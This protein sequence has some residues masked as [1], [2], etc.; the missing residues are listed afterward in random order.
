MKTAN[1]YLEK[2]K[3]PALET[4]HETDWDAVQARMEEACLALERVSAR[5]NDLSGI[6]GKMKKAFRS[7]CKNAGTGKIFTSLIPDDLGGSVLC[8]GLNVIFTALQQTEVHREAVYKALE[9]L[10][11]ILNNHVEYAEL[12]NEDA[13]VHRRTAKLYTEVLITLDH[14]LRWFMTN[15]FGEL[16]LLSIQMRHIC[17]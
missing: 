3:L 13:E 8:G 4:S 7:L 15:A 12:A 9:R 10:P 14:I 17:S 6:K 5:E 11:S 1:K 2:L 16:H